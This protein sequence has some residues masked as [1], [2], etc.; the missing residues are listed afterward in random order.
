MRQGEGGEWREEILIVH[1][2]GSVGSGAGP[3]GP[4]GPAQS[5]FCRRMNG[6]SVSE[7][8]GEVCI[9]FTCPQVLSREDTTTL[10]C[11]HCPFVTPPPRLLQSGG[12][13]RRNRVH[14]HLH[15]QHHRHHQCWDLLYYLFN[16]LRTE[17]VFPLRPSNQIY[18][19]PHPAPRSLSVQAL[20]HHLPP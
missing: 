13:E 4:A 17:L 8:N 9:S 18:R 5:V 3:A 6:W 11:G 7:M 15:G 1:P 10:S 16:L 12:K 20:A 2:W 19:L 14:S